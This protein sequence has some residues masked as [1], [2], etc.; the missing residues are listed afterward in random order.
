MKVRNILF[1]CF[2]VLLAS[3]SSVKNKPTA[4]TK[5]KFLDEYI[6]PAKVM[7]D[8][9]EIGGLSGIDNFK[10]DY[11]I[12]CD[13]SKNP[14]IYTAKIKIENDKIDTVIFT[15][16]TFFSYEDPFME[17][18]FLDLESILYNPETQHILL[19]S[20]GS[21]KNQRDPSIFNVSTTGAF[22]NSYEIPSYFYAESPYKPR[23]N[24]LFEGLARNYDNTGF[25]MGTE[26]PLETD[27]PEPTTKEAYSPVRITYYDWNSE[28]PKF[29]FIYPLD[30][31]EKAPK[32]DFAVNGLS[33]L[34][35]IGNKKFLVLERSYSSGWGNKANGL[36]IYEVDA[37]NS[38]NTLE[39]QHLSESKIKPVSKKLAFNL[40]SIR[41]GLQKNTI[42]NIEGIC[43]GPT[44]A[45]GNKTLI[46]IS[47]NNFNTMSPQINQFLLF[48]IVKQ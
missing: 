29:Q 34:F 1:T 41:K 30:K 12:V 37:S 33:D 10:D 42:D 18:T 6:F 8:D 7:L 14:R 27:G 25:W 2:V 38:E 20:E 19:S 5:L 21:I 46:L 48:E 11:L 24:G 43:Y 28:T 39:T 9:T 22:V 4:D 47:D 40:E 32:G 23:H 15:N 3:C 31:I 16:T 36:K 44:L 45:N 35:T 26:L 13:D 17:N